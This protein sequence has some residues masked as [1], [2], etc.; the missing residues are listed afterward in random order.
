M[1]GLL[2]LCGSGAVFVVLAIA[3]AKLA[4]NGWTIHGYA[5]G[6]PGGFALA[7][8]VQLVSGVPF[9]ELAARWDSLAGWQRGVLGVAIVLVSLVAILGIMLGVARILYG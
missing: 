9:S 5:W 7:G 6:I 4:E 2:T 8:L 3:G 1:V